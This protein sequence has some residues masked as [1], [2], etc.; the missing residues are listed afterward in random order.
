MRTELKEVSW[1]LI[2]GL[3]VAA[4]VRP[5][6]SITGVMSQL[7]RPVA[8][9][10]VTVGISVVWIAVVGLRRVSHPILTL[11]CVGLVYGILAVVL[12]GVLSPILTGQLQG[13]LTTPLGVGVLATLV[14]NALWGALAG[15]L[16]MLVQQLRRRR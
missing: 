13:P 10:V 12:S 1:P 15:V 4:L 3:G 11:V 5:L 16:A 14:V 8:P 7:G 6:M 2:V 9:V